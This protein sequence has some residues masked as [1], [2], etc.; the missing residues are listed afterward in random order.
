MDIAGTGFLA[1]NLEPISAAHPR[2]V[3]AAAGVSAADGTSEAEFAREADLLYRL[4]RRCGQRGHKLLFFST[5]STGMYSVPGE[6]GRED[7][8]VF[9][10]T[11]YGRHKLALEGVLA[12]AGIDYLVLRLGH[13]VGPQQPPHQLLPAMVRQ[14]RSGLVRLHR[15][16]QRDL[17]D[18]AD[19]VAIADRL[20]A[21]GAN[22]TVV[23]VASGVPVPI[24]EIIDHIEAR[25]GLRAVREYV[26]DAHNQPIS[27]AKLVRLVP[28]VA[29][30][31][32]EPGYH[33]RVLDRYV[34]AA[35]PLSSAA[36]A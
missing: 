1:R 27:T 35:E 23:N 34:T 17:I 30:M 13:V 11:P 33:R 9:P 24:D 8:P 4:I 31:G 18:V 25:L 21:T 2:V 32:F 16:A 5:A 28:D 19:V 22:R 12:A 36:P 6:A 7:G 14:V 20:L 29:A 15:G 26:K 10:A 3:V